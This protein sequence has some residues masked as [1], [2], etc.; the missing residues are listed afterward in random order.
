MHFLPA[1]SL[2]EN[3]FDAFPAVAEALGGQPRCICFV[4]EPPG[5]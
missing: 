4:A 5:E 1:Q 3:S 2:W